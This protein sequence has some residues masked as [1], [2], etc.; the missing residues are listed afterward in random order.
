MKSAPSNR[1][2]TF[3]LALAAGTGTF[4]AAAES[5]APW[6]PPATE[7]VT[8]MA[9]PDGKVQIVSA[10]DQFAVDSIASFPAQ[11]G[12]AF[13]IEVRTKVEIEMNVQPELAC[14]DAQGR[15]VPPPVVA[16]Q[17]RQSTTQWQKF[18]KTF[19]AWPDTAT[20]RARLRGYGAGT[21]LTEAL[22]FR[23]AELDTYQTGALI[24]RP[25]P[26]TRAG[27]LLESNFSIVNRELI[28][29]DD[30]D[31]DG[32][33]ALVLQNL[34]ALTAPE[35]KGDDWRSNFEDNPNVI[36]WT[37]GAVLKS[38]S[39]RS[40]RAPDAVRALHFRTKVHPDP[41]TVSVGDPGRPVAVSLDGKTWQRGEGGDEIELGVL[42]LADG[43]VEL[44]I[45]ACYADRIKTGPAYFDYVRLLPAVNKSENQ[46]LFAAAR[47]KPAQLSRGKAE[48]TKV[49]VTIDAPGFAGA[50]FWPAR[51][52]LPVPQ[53][54]LI[55]AENIAVLDHDGRP[56][57]SQNRITARWPDGSARWIFVDFMHELSRGAN[58]RYTIVYGNG[59]RAEATPARVNIDRVADGL[60]VDTGA[61]RFL[62]S[63]KRFGLV[64]NVRLGS[65]Q[66]VQR[67]P[68]DAE[69]VEAGGRMWSALQQP[70]TRIEV[71]QAGPLHAVVRV[72][73]KLAESGKPATGFFHRPGFTRMPA[74]RS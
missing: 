47:K 53:G 22:A 12:E 20:V 68:I 48:E 46:R 61:V 18:T 15:E 3:L 35:Q 62:V 45:D 73:T 33:W 67:E 21:V 59:V 32:K 31:G 30:R 26:R 70:V 11:G 72:E 66:V 39:V 54:E 69:I 51:C 60:E 25:H 7:G 63:G 24:V 28:S 17:T 5:A 64:E 41:Y 42:P 4:A 44:W 74:A 38:D 10:A 56:I 65:G 8:V 36:L 9:Q 34:D 57:P 14:F 1:L 19:I 27:V 2:L 37:D 49:P 40:D 29:A 58:A 50:T 55:S 43:V 13:A 52:G 71:E 16:P 6:L 23:P